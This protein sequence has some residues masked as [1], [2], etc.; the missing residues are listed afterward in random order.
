MKKFARSLSFLTLVTLAGSAFAQSNPG[1]AALQAVIANT[2]A[3]FAP[4][5]NSA[6]ERFQ[7]AALPVPAPER[8]ARAVQLADITEKCTRDGEVVSAYPKIFKA[9]PLEENSRVIKVFSFKDSK[10]Q[11]RRLEVLFT[12]GDWMQY[13][14][15][16]FVTNAGPDK[17]QAAG[18]FISDLSTPDR[19]EG[20]VAPKVD[21]FNARQ[22]TA[23]IAADFLDASGNVKASFSSA[24]A[25]SAY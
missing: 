8:A 5:L 2:D 1:N 12:G 13:G 11:E 4:A 16:Y 3:Q 20:A 24:A 19:E 15:V 9:L 17:G 22:L 25:V 6:L 14:L 10:G 7:A 18:Y 23:F 21:P